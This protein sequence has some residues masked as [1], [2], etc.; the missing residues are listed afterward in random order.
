MCAAAS[1]TSNCLDTQWEHLSE[2]ALRQNTEQ[3]MVAVEE[4]SDDL[5]LSLTSFSRSD[6]TCQDKHEK[7]CLQGDC[8]HISEVCSFP[9]K[10]LPAAEKQKEHGDLRNLQHKQIPYKQRS[11]FL[12]DWITQRGSVKYNY[13]FYKWGQS[14]YAII[15]K[16]LC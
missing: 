16:R 4:D 12:P 13:N 5:L 1:L 10:G 3:V 6:L 14:C 15:W 11:T 9:L 2:A 8:H 7:N